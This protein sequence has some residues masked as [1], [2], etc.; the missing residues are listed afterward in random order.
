M[1]THSLGESTNYI[2]H[3]HPQYCRRV[4]KLNWV[5][6]SWSKMCTYYKL[7]HTSISLNAEAPSVACTHT[8]EF[9]QSCM[10]EHFQLS[11]VQ[12]MEITRH[13]MTKTSWHVLFWDPS[14]PWKKKGLRN[15]G[16]QYSQDNFNAMVIKCNIVDTGIQL[17]VIHQHPRLL[18]IYKETALQ[19]AHWFQE[20][21]ANKN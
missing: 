13:L 3:T 4:S 18:Y 2:Q 16:R 6:Y 7:T 15:R 14:N 5:D 8:F 11:S 1:H 12:I 21:R 17:R 10:L 9:L 19:S 20:R